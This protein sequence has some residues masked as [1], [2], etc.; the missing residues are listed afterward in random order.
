[1][2]NN[3]NHSQRSNQK[4][5]KRKSRVLSFVYGLALFLPSL[6]ETIWAVGASFVAAIVPLSIYHRAP[7]R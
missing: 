5:T 1:M 7:A 2:D 4:K 6:I 3:P